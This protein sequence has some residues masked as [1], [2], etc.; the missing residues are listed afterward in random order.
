MGDKVSTVLLSGTFVESTG[1]MAEE[2]DG[3]VKR[4]DGGQKRKMLGVEKNEH[5]VFIGDLSTGLKLVS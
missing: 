2:V 1:L 4:D 3:N 5:S